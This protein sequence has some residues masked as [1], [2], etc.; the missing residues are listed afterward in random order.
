ML[1]VRKLFEHGWQ[2][3]KLYFMIGLP[4]ETQEDIEAIVDLCRKAR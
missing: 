2:Q 4:G 1:H 3:V